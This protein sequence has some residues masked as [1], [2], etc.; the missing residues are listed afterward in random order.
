MSYNNNVHYYLNSEL[1]S[2]VNSIITTYDDDI[3]AV[4]DQ[5]LAVSRG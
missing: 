4:V 1:I 2:Q 3:Y 5:T